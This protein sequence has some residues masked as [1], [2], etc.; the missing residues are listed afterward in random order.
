M[1]SE[2]KAAPE[3]VNIN[4]KTVGAESRI[5]RDQIFFGWL[6]FIAICITNGTFVSG[7][8]F[9]FIVLEKPS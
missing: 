7:A 8:V 5:G 6:P 9:R 1:A 2:A 4:T 3:R